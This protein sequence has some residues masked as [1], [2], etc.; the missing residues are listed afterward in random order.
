MSSNSSIT[1]FFPAFNDEGSIAS[2]VADALEVLPGLADDFEVLVVNDGSAD[3]T[4]DVLEALALASPHVRVIHH[5]RNRGYGAALRTGFGHARKELIFY[6]DG[7]G[8]YDV[9]EMAALRPLLTGAVGAVNGYKIK[10]SDARSRKV[11]GGLYNRLARFLFRLPIRDVDCDFRLMRR[12]AVEPLDLVSSSGVI[13]VELVRK[14]H[15][16]GCV[17]AEAPVNHYERRHGRSQFF[18]FGRVARTALDFLVL[19]F[20]LVGLRRFARGRRDHQSA[21]LGSRVE[22]DKFQDLP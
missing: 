19:W 15:A 20:K 16:A 21:V 18:T 13:C 5:E 12:Q 11:I 4:R 14:L 10:R 17:F 6:T 3:A 9:R 22:G 2:L 1:V 7:D 8:Q